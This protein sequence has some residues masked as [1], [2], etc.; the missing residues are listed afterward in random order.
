MKENKNINFFFLRLAKQAISR[1]QQRDE[2]QISHQLLQRHIL[3]VIAHRELSGV[4]EM[5]QADVV[6][7]VGENDEEDGA[8]GREEKSGP[9]D[10]RLADGGKVRQNGAESEVA[11]VALRKSVLGSLNNKRGVV[12]ETVRRGG[13]HFS[14]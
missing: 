1:Q 6:D 3:D 10:A 2:H 5:L 9:S 7:V 12:V 14:S 4:P 11:D 13:S 8:E